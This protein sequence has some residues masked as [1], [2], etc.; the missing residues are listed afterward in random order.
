VILVTIKEINSQKPLT[1][2]IS[3]AQCQ[4]M[5]AEVRKKMEKK[6]SRKKFVQST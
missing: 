4:Q 1:G 3:R 2:F 5:M 6:I